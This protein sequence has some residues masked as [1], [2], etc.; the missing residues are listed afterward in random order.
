MTK[1]LAFIFLHWLGLLLTVMAFISIAR[2]ELFNSLFFASGA[3][4]A[5]HELPWLFGGKHG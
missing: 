5:A 2:G 4:Y 3:G 1:L